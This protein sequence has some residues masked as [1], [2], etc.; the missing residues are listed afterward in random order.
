MDDQHSPFNPTEVADVVTAMVK[1]EADWEVKAR[2]MKPW[3]DGF[4]GMVTTTPEGWTTSGL[5]TVDRTPGSRTLTITIQELP[6]GTWSSD[7]AEGV[8]QTPGDQGQDHWQGDG[9][10]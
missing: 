9:V 3:Y 2:A 8:A 6:I 10:H 1:E 7:Y 4:V 5:Y